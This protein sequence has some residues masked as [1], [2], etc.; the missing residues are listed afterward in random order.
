MAS[1][2]KET[3][4]PMATDIVQ[5]GGGEEARRPAKDETGGFF[6]IYKKGQGYWTRMGTAAA[7]ALIG[8]LTAHFLYRNLPVWIG[9][10]GVE[11]ERSRTI[12]LGIISVLCLA[13]AVL[14]FW[15]I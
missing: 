3:E 7:S 15:L 8:A 2:T 11:M 13:Y 12:S 6:H 10:M 9:A 1:A 4:K 14:V 5:S